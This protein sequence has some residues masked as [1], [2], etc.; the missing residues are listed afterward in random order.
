MKDGDK[1]LFKINMALHVSIKMTDLHGFL[2]WS[3]KAI[4]RDLGFA[5]NFG[6]G[7]EAKHYKSLTHM[8]TTFSHEYKAQKYFTY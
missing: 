8:D 2:H 5:S 6:R 1:I 3:N 4:V 7:Q